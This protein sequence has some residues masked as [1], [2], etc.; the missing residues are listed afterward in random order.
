MTPTFDDRYWESAYE[1]V[2]ACRIAGQIAP[3]SEYRRNDN[4]FTIYL[5]LGGRRSIQL[6]MFLA[7]HLWTGRLGM[8]VRNNSFNAAE[9]VRYTD[10][11]AVGSPNDFDPNTTQRR[12]GRPTPGEFVDA[13]TNSNYHLFRYMQVNHRCEGSRDWV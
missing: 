11:P 12:A 6:N 10:I 8:C 9:I 2:F 5:L 7:D 4:Y 1:Q 3:R 13:I